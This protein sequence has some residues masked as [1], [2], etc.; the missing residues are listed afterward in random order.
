MRHLLLLLFF[1]SFLAKAQKS[2]QEYLLDYKEAVQQYASHDFEGAV[3]SLTPL[4]SSQYSSAI[5]PYSLYYYAL[6]SIEIDK[7][8]QARAILRDLFQ[9]K[10]SWDKMDEAYYLYALANFKDRYYE[11]GITYLEKINSSDFKSDLEGL[12]HTYISPIENINS[13]KELNVKFPTK[14]IIAE[15]LVNRIQARKYNTKAD[16]ELSDILTDRFKL[17]SQHKLEVEKIISSYVRPYDDKIID[18]GVLLPF[19]L[20]GFDL[21][22]AT[23]KNRY[24]YDMYSGMQLAVDKLKTENI[25]VKL[26]GF[27]VGTSSESADKYLKDANFKK[28]DVLIGPL[29][30][31]P[32]KV[33]SAFAIENKMYQIHPISNS[34]SLINEASN[35]FLVQASETIQAQKCLDFA[36][37]MNKIKTVSIYFE[38]SRDSLFANTY[39]SEAKKRGYV[40]SDFKAY[41]SEAGISNTPQKGH[42]FI[43]GNSNFGPK[44]LRVL[45]QKK[46][47]DLVIATESSFNFETASRSTL[48]KN[49]YLINPRF[50]DLE[51][52][53]LKEFRQKYVAKMNVSPS[54][55]SFLGYD[56]ILFYSRMLK[57]GK[58]IFRLNLD[59]SPFMDDL[60]L[61]GFDYSN[62]SAEN[63][64]V[65]IVKYNDGRFEI[66]NGD[67]R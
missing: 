1:I 45:G 14:Y 64:I 49:L 65:P 39:A 56:I 23:T 66:V 52:E 17:V 29:Y 20:T 63:K 53:S 35:S 44:M 26:Y 62:K 40:I 46:S 7:S 34:Q 60:L 38:D 37:Q 11:E 12:M 9:R 4:T 33:T 58:E 6:A 25:P 15:A 21:N 19:S 55:Y 24:V 22:E 32:N 47:D 59:E 51:N 2:D 54:Y 42:V 28:L 16:L 27:D 8:Y 41:T 48:Q 31:R 5:V 67:E 18:F 61:S 50:N 30:G 57:D 10:I 43:V 3:A 36:E 13:L